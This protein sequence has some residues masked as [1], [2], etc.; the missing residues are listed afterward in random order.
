MKHNHCVACGSKE[1]LTQH[2]LVPRSIGGSDEDSNL[3]TFCG[4][5]HAK[6]HQVKA[7][8]R[9]SELTR[10]A[11]QIKQAKGEYIGGHAPYGFDLAAGELVRNEVE[12]DVIAQTK[13]HHM[14]GLSL[15]KI[16][17]ELDRQGTKTRKGML[18]AAPQ[19]Q[20]MLA[21]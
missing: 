5:C 8:W 13:Q 6:A 19:I 12:Q 18:F 9:H 7:D 2:H 10:K 15:R 11:M 14:A 4:S 16:A 3:L 17:A 1:N 20:R 21:A